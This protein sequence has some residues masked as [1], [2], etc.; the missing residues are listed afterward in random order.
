MF[1]QDLYIYSDSKVSE[2]LKSLTDDQRVEFLN[3][4]NASRD[5][6]EKIYISYDSTNKH[7][8]A[9]DI[10][11]A[12]FGHE[13]EKNGKEIFNYSIAYDRNNRE[14]L[15]YE[16]Y[17][18]SIPD[19]AQLQYTIGKAKGYGYRNIGF[20][21]DRGYFS[22]PNI[23]FMDNEGYQFVIMV[24]GL[25][26]F[27]NGIVMEVRGSFEDKRDSA[28]REYKTYGT[29][30]KRR[31]Y[32]SDEKER[33]FHVYYSTGK[34]H[35]ER[36]KLENRLEKIQKGLNKIKG[37]QDVLLG[38]SVTKYFDPIFHKDGTFLYAQERKAVV[39]RELQ[40]S[41]Y[42]CL[43]TS[44]KM[45]AG[46]ALRLY[47]SRDGSEKLFRGD[48]SYLGDRCERVYGPESFEG[49][50][51]VE[52]AALIIRNRIYTK[53]KDEMIEID[54]QPNYMTV[55]A[56]IRELEKIEMVRLTDQIYRMDHAV[57]KTQKAILKAFDIDAGYIKHKTAELS[58]RLAESGVC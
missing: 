58:K 2:F 57:T 56:A 41:G 1:T 47:K 35:A 45:T 46:D 20:I 39:E 31:L 37:R 28:I 29:T 7:C 13:K 32:P 49:K 27:V 11:M 6:R 5:H 38:D 48:K 36:E 19:I 44:E 51:F 17:P 50:I 52:F 4:W 9:G 43:V 25:A 34:N 33:Y 42:F 14:P 26:D 22:E 12:E 10:S 3:E 55:P 23:H 18:G 15:F 53:L 30:V 8:Q 24:K 40:L 54:K 21:L 16:D